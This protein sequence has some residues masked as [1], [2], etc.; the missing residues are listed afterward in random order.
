M[1]KF[2]K[3]IFTAILILL[4]VFIVLFVA[5][6]VHMNRNNDKEVTVELKP[7]VIENVQK[8]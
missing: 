4:A 6:V 7:D 5:E 8:K 2:L 1:S 3:R